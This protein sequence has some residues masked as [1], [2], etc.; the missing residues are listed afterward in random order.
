MH[1]RTQF[2][3]LLHRLQ[4]HRL[5]FRISFVRRSPLTRSSDPYFMEQNFIIQKMEL[6]TLNMQIDYHA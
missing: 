4:S 3:V 6:I 5:H 2:K 1:T